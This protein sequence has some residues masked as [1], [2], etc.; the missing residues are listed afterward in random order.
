[1]RKA[2]YEEAIPPYTRVIELSPDNEFA[3]LM[4][5][6]ALVRL[7]R[8]AAAKADLEESYASLPEST[9]LASA[10]ARLLAACPDKSV[11]DGPRALRLAEKLLKV[12]PSPEFELVETYG[13]ALASVGR[14]SEAAELQRRMLSAVESAGRSDLA[15]VIRR[16]L[17]LYEQG[18]NCPLPW[19]D[20]DPIFAPQPGKIMLT[21]PKEN[22]RMAR[23][24]PVSQ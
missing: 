13:M 20:D 6:M 10:L 15:A 3:R 23:G 11:R 22:F 14:H 2:H 18:Q 24:G 7:R 8:Y 1:M 19:R 16:N 12:H 21:V 5:S 4:K 17:S 9:D